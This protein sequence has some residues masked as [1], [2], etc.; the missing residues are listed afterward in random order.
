MAPKKNKS[1]AGAGSKAGGVPSPTPSSPKINGAKKSP[2]TRNRQP[3]AQPQLHQARGSRSRIGLAVFVLGIAFL[4]AFGS[5]IFPPELAELLGLSPEAYEGDDV[6]QKQAPPPQRASTSATRS[7]DA[8]ETGNPNPPTFYGNLQFPPP[9]TRPL[10]ET[11]VRAADKEKQAAIVDA[12]KHSWSAYERDAWGSDEYHPHSKHGS[13]LSHVSIEQGGGGMG[14][15]ILD[16][17]DSLL[18]LGLG[19]EYERARDW[20]KNDLT[21]EREGKFNVFE[22]TIR[23]LG[24]LLSAHALCSS[25]DPRHSQFCDEKD[26]ELYLRRAQELADKMRPAFDTPTGIPLREINLMTGEAWPDMDNWN[27][28][29][30][31]EGTTVQLEFKYLAHVSGDQSYWTI[32]ER[33]MTSVFKAMRAA[34]MSGIAP[35]FIS[36]ETGQFLPSDVRLGSRGDSFYEYLLKQWIQTKEPIYREQHDASATSI[37]QFLLR[38]STHSDPPLIFTIELRP[39]LSRGAPM[40]QLIPKQ[41]H[42]VCFLGGSFML[43]ASNAQPLP[44]TDIKDVQNQ[45]HWAIEDWVVGQELIKT[46]MDTYTKTSTGLGAEIVMFNVEG[47]PSEN[48]NADWYI[49]QPPAG[50]PPLLDARNILRPETVESLFIA[51]QLTGDQQ[52]RDWGWQMFQAF[53]KHCKVPSGGYASIDDVDAPGGKPNQVNKMETFWLSETLKYMYLLFSDQDI[54]PLTDWVFNTEAHPLPVFKPTFPTTVDLLLSFDHRSIL[55]DCGEGTQRQLT[56]RQIGGDAKLSHIQS[57]FITHLHQDHVL[58]LVPLLTA[59]MGPGMAASASDKKPAVEIYG[60]CGLRALLRTTL[61]LCYTSLSGKYVVHELLWPNQT[62][63]PYSTD[64]GSFLDSSEPMTAAIIPPPR[65]IPTLPAHES[66]LPGQDLRLH[67]ASVS[68]PKFATVGGV[69][70]SAAPILHRCPCIGYVFEE[71]AAAR[72]VPQEEIDRL[73]ANGP[74]LLEQ[75][76]IKYPRS[77]LG[78]LQRDRVAITLPDGY[79]LEP[80]PLDIPGRKLTVLGDTFDASGGLNLDQD[81]GSSSSSYG[82]AQGIVPLAMDSDVVVHEC[83]NA[84][85]PPELTQGRKVETRDEV[86]AKALTRGHSTPQVAGAFAGRV[87]ARALL[88]NHFSVRYP[89]APSRFQPF[90]PRD[91]PSFGEE[92]SSQG[93]LSKSDHPHPEDS[94]GLNST[95]SRPVESGQPAGA[96]STHA[97]AKM[98]ENERRYHVMRCI[99]DQATETWLATLPAT[100]AHELHESRPSAE[101]VRAV[102]TYDGFEFEVPQKRPEGLP[103]VARYAGNSSAAGS[104][105][106]ASD[107]TGTFGRSRGRGGRGNVGSIRGRPRQTS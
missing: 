55:V 70:V 16:S 15:T 31:A 67:E 42:L 50:Q 107:R 89:S 63:T 103:P 83:T 27:S 30:L 79:V 11:A 77:L 80:P 17:L 28:S 4:F 106:H 93:A 61:T 22:T 21:F 71:P 57:I 44:F 73:D 6:P 38:N 34:G 20:V 104:S 91:R 26:A 39:T 8:R 96:S 60:P 65:V 43:G 10:P 74:A 51:F 86:R 53:E 9:P 2:A 58:G 105:P 47:Y 52:Y 37:K 62:A 69:V 66:E 45:Y 101:R 56:S 102:A 5:R 59:L 97:A 72:P 88:L 25:S 46:C 40:V 95:A 98:S 36:P 64:S 3:Q 94:N 32:A 78:R 90:T 81:A 75:Q 87:R 24:G 29:S 41:D 1:G 85:M 23:N 68:W 12:F 92:D 100:I 35:I 14:Y 76:G 54:I 18:L 33:P 48:E 99:E 82:S 13:N 49:K 19:D 7:A 84:A